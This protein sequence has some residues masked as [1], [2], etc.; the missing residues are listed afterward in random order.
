MCAIGSGLRRLASGW[1]S[2][3][4]RICALWSNDASDNRPTNEQIVDGYLT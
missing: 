1:V 3:G 4:S 2:D